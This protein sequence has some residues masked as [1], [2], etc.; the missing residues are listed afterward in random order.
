MMMLSRILGLS[1][2]LVPAAV[3]A[4]PSPEARAGHAIICDT[5]V[6]IERFVALSNSGAEMADALKKVNDEAQDPRACGIALVMFT[7]GEPRAHKVMQGQS[8]DIVE[9]TIHAYGDGMR[10]LP[11]PATQQYTVIAAQGMDV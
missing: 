4:A 8:I 3:S 1:L 9:I 2:F 11:V 10:W 7:F 6:Q 5:A